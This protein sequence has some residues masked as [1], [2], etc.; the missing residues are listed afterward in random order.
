MQV[1]VEATLKEIGLSKNEA[2]VYFRLSELG[3]ATPNQI[4]DN[5]DIHRTNVYDA[6]T[7][8]VNKGLVTYCFID[9]KKMYTLSDPENLMNLVKEK[10]AKVKNIMPLLSVNKQLNSDVKVHMFE[11]MRGIKMICDQL[12]AQKDTILAFGMIKNVPEKM[13]SFLPF[14]HERRISQK[15]WMFHI[16]NKDGSERVKFLNTMPYSQATTLPFEYE[17]ITT[18]VVCGKLVAFYIWSEPEKGIMIEDEQMV[19]TYKNYFK[20]LWRTS[21]GTEWKIPDKPLP[22]PPPMKK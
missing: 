13:K 14:F 16:Y 22:G 6:V 20:L 12:I 11:G 21:T 4:A 19:Q 17:A 5:G 2:K 15:S 1:D 18:T 3:Q 7:K 9:E 10:E 8:L